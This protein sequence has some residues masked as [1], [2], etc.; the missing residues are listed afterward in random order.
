MPTKTS[1]KRAI[2]IGCVD[3]LKGIFYEVY[4]RVKGGKQDESQAQEGEKFGE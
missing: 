3:L 2:Q 4:E 1:N